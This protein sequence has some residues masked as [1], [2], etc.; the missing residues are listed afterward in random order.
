[1]QRSTKVGEAGE[2]EE[3]TTGVPEARSHQRRG[4]KTPALERNNSTK[5]RKVRSSRSKDVLRVDSPKRS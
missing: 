4:K 5:D 2:Q 1:M 3:V